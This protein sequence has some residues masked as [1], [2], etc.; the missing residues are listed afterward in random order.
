M[1][2]FT[3]FLRAVMPG[4]AGASRMP[5]RR[6]LVFNVVGGV[7][8]GSACVLLGFFA[9]HSI[10]TITHALGVTSAVVILL[11]VVGVLWAWHRRSQGV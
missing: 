3:A 7:M 11:V 6:F 9:A 4:L 1:G 10:S 5:Y 2:R 8:W